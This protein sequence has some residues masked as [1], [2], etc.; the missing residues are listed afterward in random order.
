VADAR[1]LQLGRVPVGIAKQ[2]PLG[3]GDVKWPEY[4]AALRDIGF[5]GFLTIEREAKEAAGK[6]I[7]DAVVFLKRQMEAL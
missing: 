1:L 7:A 6:D 4:L 2:V 5:R 3:E